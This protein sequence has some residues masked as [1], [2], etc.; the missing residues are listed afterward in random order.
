MG[1]KKRYTWARSCS[2]NS[3]KLFGPA[4]ISIQ[5]PFQQLCGIELVISE[6]LKTEERTKAATRGLLTLKQIQADNLTG[7]ISRNYPLKRPSKLQLNPKQQTCKQTASPA[8]LTLHPRPGLAR[9][10]Q[11]APSVP[12]V[13]SL[14]DIGEI[15]QNQE[16]DSADPS[17]KA[18]DHIWVGGS[19][20]V[21]FLP[22]PDTLVFGVLVLIRGP[23]RSQSRSPLMSW[24]ERAQTGTRTVAS[25]ILRT[26]RSLQ[27]KGAGGPH[28]PERH[29]QSRRVFSG[30]PGLCGGI[31]PRRCA[32]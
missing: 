6:L 26:P 29:L 14:R 10:C 32:C 16:Q 15:P 20:S 17:G 2:V 28:S 9:L 25:I 8:A 5:A 21:G 3:V 12:R 22:S 30:A 27:R 19:A 13:Y 4:S 23:K 7:S 1:S 11:T 31:S 18:C 24:E